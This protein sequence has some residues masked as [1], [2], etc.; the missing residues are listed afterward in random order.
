MSQYF[1]PDFEVVIQGL[2]MEADV[3][4]AVISVSYDNNLDQADMFQVTLNNADMRFTDSPLFEIGK[5]VEIHMG[6]ANN[7]KPMMLGEIIA[8]QPSF[9]EG[10]APVITITGYDKS[11]RMRHNHRTRSY[12]FSNS[13]LIAAQIAAENF[14]IPVVDPTIVTFENKT[15]NCSDMALLKELA[16]RTFFETYVHWDKLY[17]RLPRPQ[18]EAVVLEWGKNLGS[19]TP[20]LS[21]S[22]QTGLLAVQDYDQK[23]AQTIIGLVPISAAEINLD[24]LVERLGSAFVDQLTTFGRIHLS[25]EKINSFPDATAFAKALLSEILDGLFEGNG[26]CIG[27]S[28]LRAGE[29]VEIQGVGRR[30]SGKYR[31][32]KVTHSINGSGYKTNFEVTQKSS[33]TFVQIL[34]KTLA[35]EPDKQKKTDHPVVG[36]VINNL[37]PEGLGRVLVRYPWLSSEVL[38]T[39]ARVVQPDIGN[40]FMPDIG[41]DVLISFE[42]G[43]FDRP[44]VTGAFW[45][46]NKMP[47]E[48][49]T[50]TNYKRVI[51]SRVGHRIVL[52]DTPG[53]G[54]ITLIDK[55]GSTIKLHSDG[56][57]LLDAVSDLEIKAG[58][59]I[60]ITA[61][62]VN[63]NVSE[64]MDVS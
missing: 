14:L 63:V 33:S 51:Q 24:D 38:S 19:F 17:F 21:S 7:L 49:P 46:V 53:S 23:L 61:K 8:I 11:H 35:L 43:D 22:R 5:D 31:L 52:D 18:T 37:D 6:Y 45:N 15:Q 55:S 39:W 58:N 1:A 30:F 29:I 20:R 28:E 54:G 56:K 47:P 4:N 40:Y 62:N 59:D 12:L 27:I 41:D 26:S 32:R 42:M 16:R 48:A 10:G 13:S 34:R 2:T 3:K 36:T 44:I 60:T 9:P 50:P 57:I 64:A 25:G